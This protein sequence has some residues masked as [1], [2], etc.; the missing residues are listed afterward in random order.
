MLSAAAEIL[1]LRPQRGPTFS[2]PSLGLADGLV[3]EVAQAIIRLAATSPNLFAQ[4]SEAFFGGNRATGDSPP[5]LMRKADYA[6]RIGY[7]VRTLD[8][9]IAAG[10][11]VRGRGKQVRVVVAAADRWLLTQD[12]AALDEVD[13]LAMRNAKKGRRTGSS[14]E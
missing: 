5:L 7:A 4:L 1:P 12:A 8:K 6:D 14:G 11:P 13:L 2:P 10:L 9:F 3:V